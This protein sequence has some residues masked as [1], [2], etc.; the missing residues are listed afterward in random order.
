MKYKD[1]VIVSVDKILEGKVESIRPT[2]HINAILNVADMISTDDFGKE[3]VVTSLLDSVHSKNSLHYSG[4]A[5]DLRSSIYTA[6]EIETF[7]QRLKTIFDKRYDIVF[8]G[9]HIHIEYDPK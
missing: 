3:I 2:E 6:G 8:E 9:D 1:G 7:I 5:V 4:N